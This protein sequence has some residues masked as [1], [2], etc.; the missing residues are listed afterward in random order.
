MPG[1]LLTVLGLALAG[2]DPVAAFAAVAA[3][4][5]GAHRRLVLIFSVI[6]LLLPMAIGTGLSLLLNAGTQAFE[7]PRINWDLP[8]WAILEVAV[9]IA[10]IMWAVKRGHR[11]HKR[12]QEQGP[13]AVGTAALLGLAAFIG[14]T[15]ALD[16]TFLG[17]AVL[18]GREPLWSIV[19]AQIAYSLISQSPLV[20]VA[21]ATATG[22]HQAVVD[23]MIRFRERFGPV[24][25][26]GLTV[27]LL[28][29]AAVLLADGATYLLSGGN[30]YLIG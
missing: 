20:I 5:A 29:L 12:A 6:V 11:P 21:I 15:I 22:R 16:P 9:A 13:K 3:L 1:F 4:T 10:L 27:V 30:N 18:A 24:L 28:L 17:V 25:R 19:V 2:I 7:P 8:G 14:S 23:V 26:H